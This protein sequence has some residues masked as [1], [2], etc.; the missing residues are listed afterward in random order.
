[1][2]TKGSSTGL[3]PSQVNNKKL[4]INSQKNN[5]CIGLNEQD[6]T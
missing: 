4:E 1:M 6:F 5:L 3:A 2:N